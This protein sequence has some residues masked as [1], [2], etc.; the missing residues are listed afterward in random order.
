[1]TAE[2]LFFE[3]SHRS[4]HLIRTLVLANRS[5]Y[6][7]GVR[8]DSE[9]VDIRVFGILLFVSCRRGLLIQPASDKISPPL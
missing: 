7:D 4:C 5:L 3:Q 8:A 2:P 6:V 9:A 1:M